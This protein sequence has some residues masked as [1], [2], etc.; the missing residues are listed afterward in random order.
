M[1]NAEILRLFISLTNRDLANVVGPS[2]TGNALLSIEQFFPDLYSFLSEN[3]SNDQI[4]EFVGGEGDS[5]I[6]VRK[7]QLIAIP[8]FT[9]YY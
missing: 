5:V 9:V 6:T 7:N 1:R 2:L 3:R 8:P 4:E